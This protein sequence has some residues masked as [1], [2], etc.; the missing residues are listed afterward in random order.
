MTKILILSPPRY[1]KLAREF[2]LELA[3]YFGF[4]NVKIRFHNGENFTVYVNHR[5]FID[6]RYVKSLKQLNY[7]FWSAWKMKRM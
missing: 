4:K 2:R 6:R 7:L 5:I 3:K 1:E